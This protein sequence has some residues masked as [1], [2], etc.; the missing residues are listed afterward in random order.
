SRRRHTRFSRDWSSDVCSSD[1]EMSRGYAKYTLQPWLRRIESRLTR[2]FPA[3][4]AVEFDLSK[5]L[6][7]DLETETQ[8]LINLLNSGVMTLNEVRQKL[9]LPP[10][11]DEMGDMHRLPPGSPTLEQ[12]KGAEDD[13][14]P[15]NSGGT[16]GDGEEPDDQGARGSI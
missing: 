9:N 6:E 2:L 13:A 7:P 1:L 10:V 11:D 15:P 12:M 5:F 8:R 16:E 4:K 14:T 3:D